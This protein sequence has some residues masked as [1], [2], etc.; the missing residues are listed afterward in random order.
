LK[1]KYDS[2]AADSAL[3]KVVKRYKEGKF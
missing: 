2:L 3:E 1:M